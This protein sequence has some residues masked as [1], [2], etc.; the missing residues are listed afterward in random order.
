M[1]SNDFP[2]TNLTLPDSNFSMV[3]YQEYDDGPRDEQTAFDADFL[4]APT[5]LV[6]VVENTGRGGDHSYGVCTVDRESD[7]PYETQKKILNEWDEF[8]MACLPA[9]RLSVSR[10][11]TPEFRS[12]WDGKNH[13]MEFLRDGVVDLFLDEWDAQGTFN[14]MKGIVVRTLVEN[15][16]TKDY[17]YKV[18]LGTLRLSKVGGKYWDKKKRNWVEL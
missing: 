17:I 8:V 12:L 14:R 18:N 4:H 10:S 11:K 2:I 13:R 1:I 9:L 7:V 5:G 3:R 16:E 15:G 6:V